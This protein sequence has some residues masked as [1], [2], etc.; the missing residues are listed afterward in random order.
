MDLDRVF[1]SKDDVASAVKD[2]LKQT[3]DA[4]GYTI[5]K[6]LVTDVN[7]DER[8]KRAMNE[9]NASKRNRIAAQEKAEADKLFAV[10]RAEAEAQAKFLQGE[11]IARQRKAIVEGLRESVCDFT[12]QFSG[13][14]ASEVLDLVLVTQYFDTLKDLSSSSGHQTVFVPHN[15]GSLHVLAAELRAGVMSG[16]GP[17]V[18]QRAGQGSAVE[19]AP[20]PQLHTQRSSSRARLA[21]DQ[22]FR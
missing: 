19:L 11:G 17:P 13:L 7:P 1:E 5:V 9:I 6:T 3:M 20:A 16:G 21:T 10:K 18:A 4:F 2:S 12:N 15:P 22:T 14:E 8:V